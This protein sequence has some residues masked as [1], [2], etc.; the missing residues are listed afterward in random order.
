MPSVRA[1]R[2]AARVPGWLAPV[3]VGAAAAAGAAL[4]LADRTD[5][6]SRVWAGCPF[7]LLTGLDCP[8]CGGTRAAHALSRGDL[9]RALDH[10]L[11]TVS[12]LPLLAYGWWRWLLEGFGRGVRF[13][14]GHRQASLLTAAVL[15]FWVLRN[16]PWFSWLGSSQ[17]WSL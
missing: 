8:G 6:I 5:L 11:M 12:L 14:L 1:G 3:S 17:S 16:L 10:N 7:R 9:A 15:S 4:L 2:S 13:E